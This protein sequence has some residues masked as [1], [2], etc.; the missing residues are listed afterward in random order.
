MTRDF[1]KVLPFSS[2]Y[3]LL[4]WNVLPLCLF[5]REEF[6]REVSNLLRGVHVRSVVHSRD[7][8]FECVFEASNVNSG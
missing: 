3:L 1:C 8:L 5:C 4:C 2:R 6:R 7:C